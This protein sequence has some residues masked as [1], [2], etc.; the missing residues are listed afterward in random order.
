MEIEQT[1]RGLTSREDLELS[2]QAEESFWLAPGDV[3]VDEGDVYAYVRAGGAVYRAWF[4]VS[5]ASV[6]YISMDN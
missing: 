6:T 1:L 3:I 5:G 2:L 4:F